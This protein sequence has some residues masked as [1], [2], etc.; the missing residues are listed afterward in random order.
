[1]TIQ[2]HNVVI[3]KVNIH[4]TKFVVQ[5]LKWAS[6]INVFKQRQKIENAFQFGQTNDILSIESLLHF[7][8]CLRRGQDHQMGNC[9]DRTK[10]GFLL[11]IATNF[12]GHIKKKQCGNAE[13]TREEKITKEGNSWSQKIA[14]MAG[15]GLEK[16]L[17]IMC[18][19]QSYKEYKYFLSQDEE[20]WEVNVSWVKVWSWS[21]NFPAVCQESL[22]SFQI[23]Q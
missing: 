8:V 16:M 17:D 12:P 11:F 22:K 1:M 23:G 19:T 10:P 20:G 15:Q 2:W 7:L 21:K 14:T 18:F 5:T 6:E 3:F 4:S 9:Y 13:N